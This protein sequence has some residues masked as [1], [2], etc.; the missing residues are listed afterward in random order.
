MKEPTDAIRGL[1]NALSRAQKK[2][3]GGKEGGNLTEESGRAR[4]N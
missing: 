1:S 4:I 2:S 3:P